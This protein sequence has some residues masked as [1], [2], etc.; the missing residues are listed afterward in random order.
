MRC[1]HDLPSREETSYFAKSP[2]DLDQEYHLTLSNSNEAV[3]E[4]GRNSLKG[5][6]TMVYDEGFNIEFGEL[7][8]FAFSKYAPSKNS[9]GKENYVSYCN[10]TC[11]GWYHNKD[12]TQW[13]CYKAM[14]K[15]FSPDD[16]TYS[17]TK[18]N[19]NIVD[20]NSNT[21][22]YLINSFLDMNFMEIN[23]T[24]TMDNNKMK[25]SQKFLKNSSF[26][27]ERESL[28]LR[29]DSSFKAHNLYLNKLRHVKKSWTAEIH[30][31]FSNLS[32][33]ELNRFAGIPRPRTSDKVKFKQVFQEDVSMFPKNFDWKNV[34]KSAGTQG[35][36]GS[37]YTYS[38]VRM[39]ESRLKILYN[40]DV[41]L[42]VQHALDCSFYNQG[43]N[44]GYPYLT[45]KFANEF[46]LLPEFC[47][48]YAV[49]F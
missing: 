36:C 38:T 47:K 46:G 29:L 12:K 1:G 16:I 42:S 14:K 9:N 19:M 49:S 4:I 28:M 37:C 27:A 33:K 13:G 30:P 44:G 2:F 5:K 32:I 25:N 10:A 6:W 23:T 22:N 41:T 3:I 11:V 35:N 26:I 18:N 24:I 43:C 48:P 21:D 20:P 45:M 31:D 15:G 8:F 34:L 40:H 7:N 39:I 17:D